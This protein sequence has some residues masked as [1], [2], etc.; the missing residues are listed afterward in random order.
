MREPETCGVVEPGALPRVCGQNFN[1]GSGVVRVT[2]VTGAFRSDPSAVEGR[3]SATNTTHVLIRRAVRRMRM[4]AAR[5]GRARYDWRIPVAGNATRATHRPGTRSVLTPVRTH[6][7][8]HVPACAPRIRSGTRVP[9]CSRVG[10][11][12]VHAR[13]PSA[14]VPAIPARCTVCVAPTVRRRRAPVPGVRHPHLRIRQHEGPIFRRP[15][16][17]ERRQAI[18]KRAVGRRALLA[19][20][21]ARARGTSASRVDRLVARRSFHRNHVCSSLPPPLARRRP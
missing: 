19:S 12:T 15:R 1:D 13:I 8:V 17:L 10:H 3:K 4:L 5:S 9:V 21:A 6:T 18:G 14:V 16:V 20:A 2:W 11:R 7:D